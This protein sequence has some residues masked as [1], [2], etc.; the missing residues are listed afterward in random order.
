MSKPNKSKPVTETPA[1]SGTPA[2]PLE[3]S[4]ALT[5]PV[6][7]NYTL[8][9]RADAAPTQSKLKVLS[10]TIVSPKDMEPGD[11]FEA[12]ITGFSDSP[13]TTYKNR[14]IEFSDAQGRAFKFPCMAVIARCLGFIDGKEKIS[15][16]ELKSRESAWI[17][18]T[19]F[20]QFTG[21]KQGAD[22]TKK[23]TKTFNVAE[24]ES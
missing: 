24:V 10:T 21:E 17:G 3:T 9:N 6:K 14:L 5:A 13:V 23:P 16:K 2:A 7:R 8:F 19:L 12:K 20:V 1:A 22:H 4:T 11:W 18:R 15:N